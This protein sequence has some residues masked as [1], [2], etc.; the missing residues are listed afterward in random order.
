MHDNESTT[1]YEGDTG[2]LTSGQRRA[3]AELIRGPYVSMLT[4]PEIFSIVSSSREVLAQQ[5]DNLFLTLIIDDNAGV[6]Y[7]KTWEADHPDKR[8]MLRTLPLKFVDTVVLLHL[9]KALIHTNPNERTIVDENEVFEAT[10][11]YQAAEG[12]DHTKQRKRFEAA[13]NK[14]KKN[15]IEVKTPTTGRY[16][17]SPVLRILFSAEEIAAVTA[18]YQQVLEDNA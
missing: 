3:L 14:F 2:T 12:T 18:S 8:A 1:L 9:R 6:A 10:L 7:T 4:S 13:W 16:E 17:V 15:S 5:L 11:P